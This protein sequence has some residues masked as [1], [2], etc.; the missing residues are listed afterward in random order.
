[1]VLTCFFTGSNWQDWGLRNTR[2][3]CMYAAA[4]YYCRQLGIQCVNSPMPVTY[5]GEDEA[6]VDSAGSSTAAHKFGLEEPVDG[7]STTDLALKD[8][9]P[10]PGFLP[11]PDKRSSKLLRARKSKGRKGGFRAVDGT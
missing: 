8:L 11:P 10:M 9:K 2:K 3:T 4:N 7:S 6:N 5:V 1:M